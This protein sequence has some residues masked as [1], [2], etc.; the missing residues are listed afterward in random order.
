MNLIKTY[1]SLFGWATYFAFNDNI[2]S[3]S[4]L[5]V[6][7]IL[8]HHTYTLECFI[9]SLVNISYIRGVIIV[10]FLRWEI[11]L[12]K[13]SLI[14]CWDIYILHL[15]ITIFSREKLSKKG[16]WTV[17]LY[18]FI[19]LHDLQFSFIITNLFTH[20]FNF[21]CI[22]QKALVLIL[23]FHESFHETIILLTI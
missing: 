2:W 14:F 10:A 15:K 18:N 3:F 19:S 11:P 20:W 7:Q 12:L 6:D 17:N 8:F 16:I 9:L 4:V 23:K 13:C 22:V 5:K 21:R 1:L